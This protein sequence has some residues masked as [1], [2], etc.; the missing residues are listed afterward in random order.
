VGKVEGKDYPLTVHGT[1]CF[2]LG[3]VSSQGHYDQ[4]LVNPNEFHAPIF[5]FPKGHFPRDKKKMQPGPGA[6]KLKDSVGKQVLSTKISNNPLMFGKGLRPPL[7]QASTSEFV[8]PG[9]YGCGVPACEK[10]LD[11]RKR[12]Q[13][14][15]KF[16][17]SARDPYKPSVLDVAPPGPGCYQLPSGL[18]G[19]GAAYPFRA[20]P[21]VSMSG[22][23]KFGSPF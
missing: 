18:C 22:R 14:G 6:Y 4:T 11:S 12:T 1:T 16:G 8:G 5:S 9:E 7:L 20:L 23:E 3:L 19:K 2:V 17:K 15:T 10:Q 13:H 21:A